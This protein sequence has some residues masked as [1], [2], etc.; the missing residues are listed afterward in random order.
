MT[1]QAITKGGETLMADPTTITPDALATV[2]A[3]VNT[4]DGTK[5][6][7]HAA[8]YLRSYVESDAPF[9]ICDMSLFPGFT[10]KDMIQNFKNA[11]KATFHNTDDPTGFTAKYEIPGAYFVKYQIA[12]G[13]L[14]LM[15]PARIK[16]AMDA[17]AAEVAA[18]KS[19]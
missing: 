1:P 17:Q 5:R 18:S 11:A 2:A 12:D 15:H 10:Q 14:Y 19:Q 6:Q 7:S 8:P 3:L 16:A 9:L 13:D 4:T